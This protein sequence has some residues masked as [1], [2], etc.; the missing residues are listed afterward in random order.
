MK[1]QGKHQRWY[2]EP[3]NERYQNRDR[4]KQKNQQDL[5]KFIPSKPSPQTPPEV[6]SLC[7]SPTKL[8]AASY[9]ASELQKFPLQICKPVLRG[10]LWGTKPTA[11][12]LAAGDICLQ[13]PQNVLTHKPYTRLLI[14]WHLTSPSPSRLPRRETQGTNSSWGFVH[15][16]IDPEICRDS[17]VE[18]TVLHRYTCGQKQSHAG[19]PSTSWCQQLTQ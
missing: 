18:T 1:K 5:H 16:L 17:A 6:K 2:E 10:P 11:F 15:M 8:C 13:N 9:L 14:S 19:G 7:W 4:R 3:Q 12:S